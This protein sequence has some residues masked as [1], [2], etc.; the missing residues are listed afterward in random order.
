MKNIKYSLFL[1][2][3]SAMVINI[4]CDSDFED[5]NRDPNNPTEIAADRLLANLL[6]ST[7]N[8][9]YASFTSL[10]QGAGWAQQV[11]KVQY[12]DEMRYI[13]RENTISATWNDFYRATVSDANQMVLIGT[14]RGDQASVAI[15]KIMTAYGF[16]ILT[17]F[18]G[19]IPFNEALDFT[20][21]VPA[22]DPQEVVYEGSLA[23][24]QEAIDILN[25][26]DLSISSSSDL[27]YDGDLEKW[28]KFAGS[29]KF[30]ALM[31]ISSKVD[32]SEDLQELVDNGYLFTSQEDEA[33]FQFLGSAPNANPIYE[34]IVFNNREEYKINSQ[35]VMLM[36]SFEDPRLPVFA[37]PNDAGIIR[38]K[39]SGFRDLPSEEFS[40]TNVSAFGTKYLNPTQPAYFVS[41]TELNFLLAEAA[42]KGFISGGDEAAENFYNEG[43]NS[44]FTENGLSEAE[45]SNFSSSA[46]VSYN[47]DEGL[48]QIGLQKYIGL[49]GQGVEVW[50]EW[51]RTGIPANLT[52]AIESTL[53]S[54]PVR[55]TYPVI[56]QSLNP[57]NYREAVGRQGEDKLTTPVWWD[58]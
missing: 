13:P 41:Y 21:I 34:T 44:S 5:I 42:K 35:L 10:D 56:E 31:R 17:D 47:S 24:L 9:L 8:Q 16:L 33:K 46:G 55:F 30:R 25:G 50:V 27:L 37:Q 38:G 32:V 6:L 4:S 53:G 29:L 23:L 49:F 18:F 51:R 14:E 28:Q 19:D 52:P 3:F 7:A 57:D 22:Y 15:G 40:Y 39:P 11:A 1:L 54:I 58:K 12:N 48:E 45:A 36:E 2:V 26:P 20:N 43:L